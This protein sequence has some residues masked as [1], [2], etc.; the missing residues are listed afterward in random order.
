[1]L[2]CLSASH[3]NAPFALLEQLSS[4]GDAVTARI[5]E[6]VSADA[7][8]G[9]VVIS[10]CNR[11][12]AYLD[13]HDDGSGATA[14]ITDAVANAAGVTPDTLHSMWNVHEGKAAAEH[15]FA[16]SSGLE[17]VVVGEGEIAGQVRRALE[18]AREAGTTTSALERLFQRAAHTSRGIKNTTP[19]G[20]AG[21]SIVRLALDLAES[22]ISDW[23]TV[24]VLLVGTGAYAG[25]SLAALRERGV[26]DVAVFSPSGRAARFAASHGIR[27]VDDA[28]YAGEAARATVIVTCTTA[29]GAVLD[30][31]T[32][33][34]G[35]HAIAAELPRL[36]R[37]G[38]PGCPVDHTASQLVIDLGL[39]RNVDPDVARVDGVDLLDLETIR[40]HA[41]L[42]ELQ[43]TDVARAMVRNAARTFARSTDEESLAPAV[44]AL[45]ARANEVLDEEIARVRPRDPDGTAERALRHMMGRLVHT[46][47]IRAR[48][49][50]RAGEHERYL[51]A[52]QTL[53]GI[54]VEQT[55]ADDAAGEAAS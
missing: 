48:E 2:L 6:H 16:V 29:S 8:A 38:T 33:R 54:T 55:L 42:D 40:I 52:L 4:S 26:T 11:F 14:A 20:R 27:R 32:L 34:A 22:R 23:S 19:I 21:R 25:A 3:K 37:D 18:S 1:M 17:S 47:T 44:V 53:L 39:P 45:R 30:A 49:S 5:N 15:L 41:P 24:R 12:E 36:E 43:A 7:L 46:P 35:R 51:D 10:T 9:A 31:A 13:V 50:A 28:E